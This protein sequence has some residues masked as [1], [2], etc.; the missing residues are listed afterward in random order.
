[1]ACDDESACHILTFNFIY[2]ATA[3]VTVFVYYLHPISNV[4]FMKLNMFNGVYASFFFVP[5]HVLNLYSNIVGIVSMIL[6]YRFSL[7]VK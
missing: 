1:M 4:E 3:F 6:N 5:P 7:D 2:C